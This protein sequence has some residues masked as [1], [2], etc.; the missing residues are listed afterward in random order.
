MEQLIKSTAAYKIF[1]SEA[2]SG[3]LSHAYML[4]FSDGA[5]LR[6]ALKLFALEYFGAKKGS[7]EEKL[8][9]AESLPD[10]KVYPAD[11]TKLTVSAANAIISDAA[12]KPL[13]YD[14]KLYIISGFESAAP[15]FQNKLLKILEE[16]PRGVCFLLG[17]TSLASVLATVKSRVKLLEIPPFTEGEIYSALTRKGDNPLNAQA[18]RAC[19]GVLGVA[20]GMVRG[21]WYKEVKSAADEICRA[22]T[23]GDA[24]SVALKYGDFKYKTE[25]LAEMQRIYF[26]ELKRYAADE[27]FCGFIT[28]GAAS[29]AANAIGGALRDVRFNANFSSLLFD[30]ALK[31][32]SENEKWLKL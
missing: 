4:Y 24:T 11:G 23:V 2:V 29:Y 31:V 32:A 8:I 16:P 5:N 22:V 12:L 3:R 17:T 20:E 28:V 1:K 13:E 27:N 15:V 21:D 26:G 19:G 30:L 6:A 10:M 14:K 18:A 25:L 7:R 9:L